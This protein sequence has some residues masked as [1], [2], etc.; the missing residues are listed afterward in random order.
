[1]SK[2]VAVVAVN[3]VNGLGLFSYLETFFENKIDYR[4]FA[5]YD[6][7]NIRTNSGVALKVDDV[8]AHLVGKSNEYDALVFACGDAVPVFAQNMD[9]PYNQMLLQVIKEFGQSGKLLI[10]HCGAGVFFDMA[11]VDAGRQ[12]ACHPYVK[13]AVKNGI[14]SDAPYVVD[15]TLFTAAEENELHLMLPEVVKALQ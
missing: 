4:V 15:G 9:K 1:M 8:I 3:P 6:D 5:V 10:G 13:D 2:K 11:E 7:V 14:Y 12:V